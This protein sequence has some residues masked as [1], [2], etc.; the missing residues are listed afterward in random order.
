MSSI[1]AMVRPMTAGASVRA[2][3]STSGSSGMGAFY[4]IWAVYSTNMPSYEDQGP[5][6]HGPGLGRARP[7]PRHPEEVP[8]GRA[9]LRFDLRHDRPRPGHGRPGLSVPDRQSPDH[10]GFLRRSRQWALLRPDALLPLG[11]RGPRP[12]HVR[13]RDRLHRRSGAA[14]L[15]HRPRRLRHR[16]GEEIM[17]LESHLLSMVIYAFFVA[18]V[19]SLIRRTDL[20]GC[21]LY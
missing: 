20:K 21:L 16:S 17:I 7:R 18:L 1:P 2:I 10:P 11:R 9:V 13:V 5:R 8:S 3:V 14:Q 6:R 12:G 15:P 19:L 4:L